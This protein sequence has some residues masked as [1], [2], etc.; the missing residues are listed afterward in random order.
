MKRYITLILTVLIAMIA[1][2]GLSACDSLDIRFP[3]S[4]N[5]EKSNGEKEVAPIMILD[6]TETDFTMT[7]VEKK[8]FYYPTVKGKAKLPF[9]PTKLEVFV[10]GNGSFDIGENDFTNLSYSDN[11]Y[12][13]SFEKTHIFGQLYKGDYRVTIKA[14]EQDKTYLVNYETV[15]VVDELYTA[16]SGVNMETG[17]TFFAM[18]KESNWTGPYVVEPIKNGG[19]FVTSEDYS[20]KWN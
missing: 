6:N 11:N 8:S 3:S 9:M 2:L 18:D 13:V 5:S 14:Y 17:E 12:I 20:G 4:C 1:F 10:D 19:T 16:L 15:F 7:M